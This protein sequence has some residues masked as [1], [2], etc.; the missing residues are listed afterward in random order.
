MTQSVIKGY[1]PRASNDKTIKE[2]IVVALLAVISRNLS[3]GTRKIT[4][5]LITRAGLGAEM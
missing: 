4:K 5:C 1:R 2:V 3:G